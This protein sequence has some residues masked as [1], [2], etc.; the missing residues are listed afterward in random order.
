MRE[1]LNLATAGIMVGAIYGL[2]AV[3]VTQSSAA[4]AVKLS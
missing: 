2:I 4:A 3:T 1:L